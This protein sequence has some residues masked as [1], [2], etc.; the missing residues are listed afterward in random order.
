MKWHEFENQLFV[1]LNNT[2]T[3]LLHH[4][5][6]HFTMKVSSDCFPELELYRYTALTAGLQS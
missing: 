1:N 4:L 3:G 5:A 6:N 2:N